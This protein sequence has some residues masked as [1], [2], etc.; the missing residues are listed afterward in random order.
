MQNLLAIAV[1]FV[2]EIC[3]DMEEDMEEVMDKVVQGEV[4]ENVLKILQ[5]SGQALT[6]LPVLGHLG[7]P[8]RD[9]LRDIPMTAKK[10]HFSML[11]SLMICGTSL[12]LKQT[13]TMISKPQLNLLNTK[14]NGTRLPGKKWKPSW[15]L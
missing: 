5:C 7:S 2:T 4:G 6:M 3:V 1:Q 10:G 12:S 11:C 15:E 8:H 14:G 9:L 13:G